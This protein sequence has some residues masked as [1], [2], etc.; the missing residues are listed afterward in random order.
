MR[1]RCARCGCYLS[2]TSVES[3][4]NFLFI[5]T[6]TK[7]KNVRVQPCKRCLRAAQVEA[8]LD[9]YFSDSIV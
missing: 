4:T 7:P 2:A 5:Y 6:L 9:G 1:L 3:T 8:F